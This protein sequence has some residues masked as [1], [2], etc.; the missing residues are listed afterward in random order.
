MG[1]KVTER[2]S[3]RLRELITGRDSLAVKAQAPLGEGEGGNSSR[4]Q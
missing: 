2:L 4:F 3:T 1:S